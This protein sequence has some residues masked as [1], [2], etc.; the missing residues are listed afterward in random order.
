MIEA[1]PETFAHGRIIKLRQTG[2]GKGNAVR[3]G[4]RAATGDILM[5]LDADLTM[6]PE[7]LP[8]FVE[9]LASRER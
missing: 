8:K 4:F 1:L 2:N 9:V 7:D 3:E 6:P 5:I